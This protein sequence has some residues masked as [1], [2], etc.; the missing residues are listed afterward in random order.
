M[1]TPSPFFYLAFDEESQVLLGHGFTA[2]E[3][4]ASADATAPASPIYILDCGSQGWKIWVQR[5]NLPAAKKTTSA[6]KWRL[7]SI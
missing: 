4:L 5:M 2:A 3:A 1:L 6:P 7:L